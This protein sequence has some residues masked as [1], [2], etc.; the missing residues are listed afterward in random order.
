ML[1]S[2]NLNFKSNISFQTC[3]SN[4]TSEQRLSLLKDKFKM[5][6]QLTMPPA[7]V[8]NLYHV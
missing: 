1:V 4:H 8:I 6:F 2:V 3:K 7:E 5:V